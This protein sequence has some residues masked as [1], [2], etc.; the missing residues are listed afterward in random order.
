SHPA[1][2]CGD[3][4]GL[5][6]TLNTLG[7]LAEFPPL[8]LIET[9]DYDSDGGSDTK[10][11]AESEKSDASDEFNSCSSGTSNSSEEFEE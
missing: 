7:T 5:F 8:A 4:Y 2:A 11:R 1:E 9:H 10:N 3:V 6:V